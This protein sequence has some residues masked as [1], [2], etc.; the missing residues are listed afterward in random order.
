MVR[1]NIHIIC[2][3]RRRHQINK[4]RHRLHMKYPRV[5]VAKLL[6]TPQINP[7]Q[8]GPKVQP[9]FRRQMERVSF[10]QKKINPQKKN[11]LFQTKQKKNI[12]RCAQFFHLYFRS[13]T[14]NLITFFLFPKLLRLNDSKLHKKNLLM[15]CLFILAIFFM[16]KH[17]FFSFFASAFFSFELFC[18]KN[19]SFHS[20]LYMLS[21]KCS[22]YVSLIKVLEEVSCNK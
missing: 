22:S 14:V 7:P 13:L 4:H 11:T 16:F 8:Q 5:E 6:W 12:F 9:L 1:N 18:C 3:R 2:R 15:C 19:T 20:I 17:I 10:D 21:C